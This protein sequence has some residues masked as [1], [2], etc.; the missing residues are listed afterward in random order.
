MEAGTPAWSVILPV[1]NADAFVADS[2][3]ALGAYLAQRPEFCELI[4]VD[5][6]SSDRTAEVIAAVL[7]ELGVAARAVRNSGNQG[8]GAAVARGMQGARGAWRMFLDADLAYPPEEIEHVVGALAA[9]ADVAIASR[10]HPGSRYVIRPSFFR[11]LYTRHLAGRLFNWIVRLVLLPGI[12]DSQAGLKGFTADSSAAL[13]DGWLPHG[14]AFDLAVLFRA[15]QLGLRV[16]QV[17]VLYRYD[18]EPTTVRFFLD[19]LEVMRDIVRIRLRLGRAPG[20]RHSGPAR[21]TE[22]VTDA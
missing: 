7:P 18:S 3:R 11:Y 21:R 22:E 2:L 14:F 4:I 16:A 13:F 15:R 17:P 10:V 19:T 1:Y 6:G 8:K 9:G 5:D 12:R 20:K